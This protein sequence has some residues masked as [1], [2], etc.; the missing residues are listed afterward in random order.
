MKMDRNRKAFD[1]AAEAAQRG[2]ANVRNFYLAGKALARLERTKTLRDKHRTN[3]ANRRPRTGKPGKKTSVWNAVGFPSSLWG[4]GVRGHL[5]ID[6][7]GSPSVA[8][9]F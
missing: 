8:A 5:P 2:P 3:A 7:H 1:V 9:R 4:I 6:V